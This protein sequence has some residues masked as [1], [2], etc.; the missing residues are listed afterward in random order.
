MIGQRDGTH[1]INATSYGVLKGRLRGSATSAAFDRTPLLSPF[2][3]FV[4][5]GRFPWAPSLRS[6]SHGQKLP[7]LWAIPFPSFAFSCALLWQKSSPPFILLRSR[8]FFC[9]K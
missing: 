2:Q 5:A 7:P 4:L 3:G 6:V 1:G 9:G 8:V